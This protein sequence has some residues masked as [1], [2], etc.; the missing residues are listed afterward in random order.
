MPEG[1]IISTDGMLVSPTVHD[2]RVLGLVMVGKKLLMPMQSAEGLTFCI[3]L[4]DVERLRADDFREGNIVL[5]ITVSIGSA[6]EIED[7]AYVYGLEKTSF[8]S[9]S[10]LKNVIL[11]F[12]A[13]GKAL[14]RLN[15][16]YG[17]ALVCI[18]REVE[19]VQDWIASLADPIG[20]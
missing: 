20:P 15:P 17:C 13:E 19:T 10:F 7:I 8:Q 16:S 18:C 6:V 3:A 2:A 1:V 14:V 12:A 4:N 5:D 11:K 9:N